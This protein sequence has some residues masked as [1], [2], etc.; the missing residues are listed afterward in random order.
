MDFDQKAAALLALGEFTIQLRDPY[1][2]VGR[3]DGKPSWYVCQSV[4]IKDGPFLLGNYG[5]GHS[6]A[7]AVL[8]HWRVLVEEL[9]SGTYLVTHASGTARR[10]VRWNGFMWQDVH[11]P[12]LAEAS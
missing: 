10:A 12:K 1:Y 5:N 3:N 6:P 2:N 4:E 7:E 8:D 9:P 11:E